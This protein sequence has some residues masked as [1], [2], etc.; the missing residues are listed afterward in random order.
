LEYLKNVGFTGLLLILTYHGGV[1]SFADTSNLSSL[2]LFFS[3]LDFSFRPFIDLLI[4][5]FTIYLFIFMLV[6]LVN[7]E[8]LLFWSVVVIGFGFG[9]IY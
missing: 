6:V 7:E 8:G 1:L 4:Y 9:L 3:T 5:L 2:I